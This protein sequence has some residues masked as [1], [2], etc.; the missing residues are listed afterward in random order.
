[1]PRSRSAQSNILQLVCLYYASSFVIYICISIVYYNRIQ[2]VHDTV[3]DVIKPSYMHK[4]MYSGS[5]GHNTK[6]KL[7]VRLN[8]AKGNEYALSLLSKL[9]NPNA[10]SLMIYS[11]SEYS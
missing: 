2:V 7:Y 3:N 9:S 1:M 10:V 11:P 8:Q 4:Y 5:E 6:Y